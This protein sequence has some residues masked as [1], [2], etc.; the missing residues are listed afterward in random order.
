[1][2]WGIS[3]SLC[4]AFLCASTTSLALPREGLWKGREGEPGSAVPRAKAGRGSRSQLEAPKPRRPKSE[5]EI[6]G[7]AEMEAISLRFRDAVAVG[8]DT[9]AQVVLVESAAAK[10][11]LGEAF[12]GEIKAHEVQAE[13]LRDEAIARYEK[14]LADRPSNPTW[15]PEIM[16]RLAELHFESENQRYADLEK[17]YSE[18]LEKVK[19]GEQPPPAPIA[20]YERAVDLYRGVATRFPR[21]AHTDAALYMM[22]I[23][24]FEG[25]KFDDSRQAFLALTCPARF[26]IP[27]AQGDNVQPSSAVRAGDYSGC[28]A[29]RQKSKYVAEAWL[30]VGEVH[31][32]MDELDPALEAYVAAASDKDG[33]LYDE[34]LIRVAWTLYLKRDFAGAVAKLDEFVLFADEAKRTGNKDAQGAATLRD[35]AVR[36]LAKCYVED[37]WDLDHRP[38]PVWG[39]DRL[40]RDYKDREGERH[41]PDIY[42][43]LG[44]L[45]AEDTQFDRAIVIWELAL[46]RWPVS[47][48]AP[49]LQRRILDA[50]VAMGNKQGARVSRDALATNYLRG[51]KWFYANESDP[52]AL[53]AAMKLVEEALV[54]TAVE[55]HAYAQELRQKGD[56]KAAEEYG[57]AARAYEAYL[58][59]YPDTPSSYKYRFAYAESLYYSEQFS[60]SA[61]AY[62]D[63]RDSPLGSKFQVDAARGVVLSL[64]AKFEAE[65]AAGTLTLPDMPKKGQVQGPFTPGNPRVGAPDATRLRQADRP[66][67]PIGGPGDL[68]VQCRCNQPALFSFQRCRAPV[69]RD[70]RSPLRQKRSHQR[71]VCD[72]R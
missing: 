54:A 27:N 47:P 3:G 42:A 63:V 49:L 16:L 17:A 39:L 33:P 13:K 40:D 37:D 14:F 62:T 12:S 32:D 64:E 21:Y 15:T 45:F 46:G 67:Q 38:D 22:G 8:Q 1:V 31:Y 36:Y 2:N 20:N 60:A 48:T 71:R 66:R 4:A 23:L 72:H 57:V 30:R 25:E 5:A 24:L 29:L 11:E 35:D 44:E 43:A 7:I 56:P 34:A 50:Q 58:Q 55:H 28:V 65:Q 9:L 69:C 68:P 18:V 52:D 59:R 19:E 6:K 53:E 10:R 26:A 70:R 61:D 51:T 41:V